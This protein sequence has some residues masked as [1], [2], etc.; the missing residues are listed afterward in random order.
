MLREA[1]CLVVALY[2]GLLLAALFAL[3]SGDPQ[4]WTAYLDS[5]RQPA[6]VI[7]HAAAL[8]YFWL[9]QTVPWFRLAPRAISLPLNRYPAAARYVVIAHYLAWAI[10]SAA[11]LWLA[12][13]F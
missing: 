12:G 8:V 4:R 13:V 10:I 7:V 6:W 11:V 1:T 9:Y 2:T 3:A 5:Q